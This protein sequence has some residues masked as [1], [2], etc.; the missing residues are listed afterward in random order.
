PASLACNSSVFPSLVNTYFSTATQKQLAQGYVNSMTADPHG[1]V[2]QENGFN[3]MDLMATEV[4]GGNPAAGT[5]NTLTRELIKCMYDAATSSDFPANFATLDFTSSLDPAVPGAFEVR[6]P[7]SGNTPVA[8]RAQLPAERLSGVAPPQDPTNLVAPGTA[9][10]WSHILSERVLIYGI[11]VETGLGGYSKDEYQWEAIRPSVS[12]ANEGATVALCDP[13]STASSMVD[14]SNFGVLAYTNADYICD[15]SYASTA[16]GWSPRVLVQRLLKF[17]TPQP[18]FAGFST[19]GGSAGGLRSFFSNKTISGAS[20]KFVAPLP[21]STPKV[22][23]PITVTIEAK[24][25]DGVLMNGVTVTLAGTNNNG[26]PTMLVQSNGTT[27]STNT[28]PSGVTGNKGVGVVEIKFCITK[29][30][31]LLLTGN[32]TVTGRSI[33]VTSTK[34]AKLNVKP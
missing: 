2:A 13:A 21:P 33:N 20:L 29:N 8:S 10:P 7:T 22:N 17:V 26:V 3:V 15:A 16:Q 27:C 31:G 18:L 32:G 9:L 23:S 34:P 11:P 28:P 5:G 25:L 12:F 6:G 30:G 1:S 19:I 14:E 4:K 24:S